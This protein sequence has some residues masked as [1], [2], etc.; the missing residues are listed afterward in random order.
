MVGKGQSVLNNKNPADQAIDCKLLLPSN[1]I[2]DY[3]VIKFEYRRGNKDK[4]TLCS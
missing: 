2:L 4:T 1:N 3:P